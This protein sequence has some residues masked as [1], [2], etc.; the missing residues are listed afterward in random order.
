MLKAWRVNSVLQ[1]VDQTDGGAYLVHDVNLDC[2]FRELGAEH[3]LEPLG[4]IDLFTQS[5]DLL[6]GLDTSVNPD[7]EGMPI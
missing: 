2:G 1:Q 6:G 7:L 4:A 5:V 3:V